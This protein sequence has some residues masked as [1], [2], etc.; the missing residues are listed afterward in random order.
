[1]YQMDPLTAGQPQESGGPG[2]Y[3]Y[4]LLNVT[5]WVMVVMAAT[6][7]AQGTRGTV[8]GKV[9]DPNG[10]V[11]TGATVRLTNM[12][13]PQDVR[14][15]QTNADGLYRFLETEPAIYQLTVTAAGF[16]EQKIAEVKVEPNRNLTFDVTLMVAGT[17]AQITISTATQELV[18]RESATLGTTVDSR[19]VVDLPLDGRNV[20]QLALLQPGVVQTGTLL[21]QGFGNGSLFRVNGNRGTE[22]NVTLDGANNNELAGGGPTGF[23][24]KPDAIQE[25]RLLTSNYEAEFGRNSGSILNVVTKSGTHT[26]HGNARIFYRPTFLS[27]ARF[28]D[29][30]QPTDPDRSGPGDK[31]RRYERKDYGGNFGGPLLLPGLPGKLLKDRAFFFVDYERRNQ[32]IGSSRSV[33]GLPTAAERQGLFTRVPNQTGAVRLLTDP[34]TG[35]P[36]PIISGPGQ[37]VRQQIDPARFSPIA[38]YYLNFLP[39]SA[40]SGATTVGADQINNFDQLTARLDLP[41]SDRHSLGYTLNYGD[42]ATRDPFAFN[43]PPNGASVPGFGTID[44]RTTNNHVFRYTYTLTPTLVNSLLVGYA[45]NRQ[46]SFTPQNTTTAAQI[47]FTG[48]FVIDQQYAGPPAIVLLDRNF[49][50][51]NTQQGP[52]ARVSENFQLQDAASWSKG[53]HRFKFGFDGTLYKQDQAF[54]F[55][56]QGL[57]GFTT[58]TGGN[59]TGDDFADFLIGN[60]PSSIQT[61]SNGQRDYRQRASALFGQDTWRVNDRLTLSLGVRWEYTSPLTDKFDRVAY[62]RP[63]ATSFLLTRGQLFD[64]NG[65]P[66]TIPAGRRAPTGVVYV[67][68]PDPVLGGTVPRGGVGKDYNNFAPR[69]GLAYTPTASRGLVSRLLGNRETVI[70]TGFGIYYGALVGDTA[71][72]QL[73]APGFSGTMGFFQFG[74][75]TL[76]DPFAPDPYPNF[77][78]GNPNQGQIPVN[79]VAQSQLLVSAPLA[80]FPQPIDPNIRTPYT[81]QYNLTI[82]RGFLNNYVVGLS[83][84]GNRGLKQYAREEINPA[85][86]TF[87]PFPAGRE[88]PVTVNGENINDRRVNPDIRQ[89]LPMLVS[90]GRSWY[91]AFQANVQKRYSRGLLFQVAYTFSKSITE[92]DTQRGQLDLLDRSLG[93]TLSSDDAPHR[94]VA[95]FIYDLPMGQYFG[96][97]ARRLVHGW[98]VGGI[99]TF[100]SGLPLTVNNT[101]NTTGLGVAP[102]DGGILSYA[103]LGAPFRLLDPRK[104]GGRA[105]NLDAFQAFGGSADFNV[106]RDFRRGTSGPNQFRLNNGI[107]NFDLIVSKETALWRDSTRMELRFEAFNVLNHTQFLDADLNL[108]TQ[109]VTSPS[110]GTYISVRESRII[111]LGARFTF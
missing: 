78:S 2:V 50:V 73:G 86:G 37:P 93:R 72:Q 79:P 7:W 32:L 9:I 80:S 100:Q 108:G 84:V 67:G 25:F 71:L 5:L 56:N 69:F 41:L 107:N 95:S 26:F 77:P 34:A 88:T 53:D 64:F 90:A 101:F 76:A 94:L 92:V 13:R 8:S 24:L 30:D 43:G 82:E 48:N 44:L 18:D 33:V 63:G 61:G 21:T 87:L 109:G 59:T 31:R 102:T 14:T 42:S 47:G 35:Q 54:L 45:R 11:L 22:N 29:Q 4:R 111:Q 62:Y 52:Q 91:N 70:R 6:G 75:G 15:V 28:I 105:F 83:Y 51:G 99:A 1:M 49:R 58:A 39:V 89:A 106:A 65:N 46:P 74:S 81:Y 66:I 12:G 97:S 3:G 10:A 103:D 85:Y 96:R 40:A 20:V 98:K 38:Q 110:F 57:I 23:Q 60:S 17:S 55:I 16:A 36:F 68:D 104:N 27:A 19:R